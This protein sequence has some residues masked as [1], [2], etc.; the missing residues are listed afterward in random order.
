VPYFFKFKNTYIGQ[1]ICETQANLAFVVFRKPQS[2]ICR[3]GWRVR[4]RIWPRP[5]DRGIYSRSWCSR[6]EDRHTDS[7]SPIVSAIAIAAFTPT[8]E[9]AFRTTD[10]VHQCEPKGTRSDGWDTRWQKS[11]CDGLIFNRHGGRRRDAHAEA[12]E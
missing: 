10:S 12:D 2:N 11:T 3:H 1:I 8:D 6:T 7:T 5:P 9:V 4:P